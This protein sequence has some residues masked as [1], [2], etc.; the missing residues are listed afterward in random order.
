MSTGRRSRMSASA[1]AGN[2]SSITGSESAASTSAT[3]DG[4]GESE[5]ISHP[6]A[7]SCIHV[8]TLATIDAI[9]RLRN[10]LFRS[11]L[12]GDA[13]MA[14]TLAPTPTSSSRPALRRMQLEIHALGAAH[15]REL[16]RPA[17]LVRGEDPVKTVDAIHR[18]AFVLDEEIAALEAR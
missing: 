6:A 1:P 14:F 3:I 4:N 13:V 5:V 8:P 12:H 17:D 9:Q 11:G 7:T 16:A 2:A 10:R 15:D 18:L